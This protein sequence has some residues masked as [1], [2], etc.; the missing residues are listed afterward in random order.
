MQ[1]KALQVNLAGVAVVVGGYAVETCRVYRKFRQEPRAGNGDRGFSFSCKYE[2]SRTKRPP[3]AELKSA[4]AWQHGILDPRAL[5]RRGRRVRFPR[6]SGQGARRHQAL[7]RSTMRTILPRHE[8][9]G[10]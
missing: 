6:L 9:G 5:E 8:Q 7:T 1:A 3:L 2:H 10:S 4:A